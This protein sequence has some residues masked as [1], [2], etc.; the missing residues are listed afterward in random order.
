[1]PVKQSVADGVPN[2]SIPPLPEDR[3]LAVLEFDGPPGRVPVKR[4]AIV[5]GRHTDDDVRVPDVRVSRHHA[6]L[7]AHGGRDGFEIH[8]LTAVRSEPNPML[9]NGKSR[10]HASVGDG[11]VITLGGVSFRLRRAGG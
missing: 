7:V 3:P 11:D 2:T 5:I 9:V 10:E 8:N 1:M 6:R 4:G